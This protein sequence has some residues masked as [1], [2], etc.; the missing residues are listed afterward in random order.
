MKKSLTRSLN[1]IVM[2]L[3]NPLALPGKRLFRQLV[4]DLRYEQVSTGSA[5]P[6][7]QQN[8]GETTEDLYIGIAMV[9]TN[10]R[11]LLDLNSGRGATLR[12]LGPCQNCLGA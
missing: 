2:F 12:W 3:P 8:L 5:R 10:Q 11:M 9:L 6:A 7:H 4:P 1:E